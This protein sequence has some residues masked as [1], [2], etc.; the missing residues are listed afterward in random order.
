MKNILSIKHHGNGEKGVIIFFLDRCKYHRYYRSIANRLGENGYY[1]KAKEFYNTYLNT[2]QRK[3]FATSSNYVQL[4]ERMIAW[5]AA[6]GIELSF[7]PSTGALVE[8]SNRIV[9][10]VDKRSNIALIIAVST[11]TISTL[12]FVVLSIL[13][14]KKATR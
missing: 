7:N 12:G 6:N 4:R 1:A 14:K 13:K 8:G 5:A 9:P 10:F 11:I 3:A 2:T